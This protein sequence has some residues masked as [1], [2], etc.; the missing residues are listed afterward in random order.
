MNREWRRGDARFRSARTTPWSRAGPDLGQPTNFFP[1]RNRFVFQV[2]VPKDFGTKEIVWTLTSK[3][4]TEK[5]Y[6]TLKPD[7]V[8]DDTVDHVEHR[9]RRRA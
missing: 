9:R 5:A 2:R 8:L 1:R 7:Y 6:G 3:G 4:R